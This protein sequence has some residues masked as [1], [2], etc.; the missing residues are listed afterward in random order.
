MSEYLGFLLPS[1]AEEKDELLIKGIP[2][3]PHDNLYQYQLDF[4]STTEFR[5]NDV[6]PGAYTLELHE[7]R[8][9]STSN[10][11]ID[12]QVIL[13]KSIQVSEVGVT[14]LGSIP[15]QASNK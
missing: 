11:A 12:C 3:F 10:E 4:V 6:E 8:Q 13:K 7:H 15:V 1:G 9:R 5:A 2:F 14:D